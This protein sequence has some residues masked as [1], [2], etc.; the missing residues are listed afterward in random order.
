MRL[1]VTRREPALVVLL[2]AALP[3]TAWAHAGESLQPY[4]LWQAWTWS[5]A[6]TVPLALTLALYV[7]GTSALWRRAG[8]GRGVR[9]WE[10]AA[11]GAG[12]LALVIALVSPL[13]ALGE[14]L[15]SAH[16]AQHELLMTVAAPLLILGR[17]LVPALFALP[18]RSR[19]SASKWTQGPWFR[20]GWA[21]LTQPSV[22]WTLHAVAIWG[23]HLPSLYDATLHSDAVHTLQHLSFLGTALLFWW[24][25]L[26]PAWSGRGMAMLSLFTTM[27]HTGALGALLTVSG[28]VWYHS[29]A[30][31]TTVWGITPL[32][33]Q[34]LGGLIM[35]IPGGLAYLVAALA[36]LARSL[37][38]SERRAPVL[39]R[40]TAVEAA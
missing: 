11:F 29:Y 28:S 21:R 27:L 2:L 20:R 18:G 10:A 14:A 33:D 1:D 31:T 23:W 24:T 19:R 4:D 36:L 35:W 16:M 30:A 26:H 15:F 37:R 39:G 22:A 12:W 13:H 25:V 5:P 6:I 34:Q 7:V 17:P 3:A 38:E 9:G 8:R 32:A 40:A